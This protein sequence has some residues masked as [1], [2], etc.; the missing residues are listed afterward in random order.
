MCTET[1]LTS[2]NGCNNNT[3]RKC[4]EGL[5]MYFHRKAFRRKKFVIGKNGISMYLLLT[6]LS[7]K[8]NLLLLCL[9]KLNASNLI[10]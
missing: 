3:D 1:N 9:Y 5:R 8:I 2:E 10:S 6:L 4:K 7:L